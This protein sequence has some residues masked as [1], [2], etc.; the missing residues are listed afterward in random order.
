MQIEIDL[1][2]CTLTELLDLLGGAADTRTI[3]GILR[4]VIKGGKETTDTLTGKDLAAIINQ[5]G[6]SIKAE[7]NPKETA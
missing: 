7:M 3:I 4:K 1:S 5:L 2:K 6:E